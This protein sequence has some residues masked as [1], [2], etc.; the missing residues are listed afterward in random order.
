MGQH[1]AA[2]HVRVAIERAEAAF[3]RAAVAAGAVVVRADEARALNPHA[4]RA[5]V[6]FPQGGW[7]TLCDEDA[8]ASDAALGALAADVARVLDADVVALRVADDGRASILHLGP[9]GAELAAV[10]LPADLADL[11]L[12]RLR[13][14]SLAPLAVDAAAAGH[15]TG[16][17]PAP[18]AS[19]AAAVDEIARRLGIARA[20]GVSRDLAAAP[21][22]GGRAL[23]LRGPEAQQRRPAAGGRAL[24]R[25]TLALPPGMVPDADLP[26]AP[27]HLQITAEGAPVTGLVVELAGPALELLDVTGLVGWNA[28]APHEGPAPRQLVRPERHAGGALVFRFPDAQVEPPP[29]IAPVAPGPAGVRAVHAHYDA[30]A[31][32]T[33][34]AALRARPRRAGEG[35]LAVR[36]RGAGAEVA[37]ASAK[38]HVQAPVGPS[39]RG[40]SA[41]MA[42]PMFG[43]VRAS[44]QK[45]YEG[46]THLVGWIGLDA[47]FEDRRDRVLAIADAVLDATGAPSLGVS[48]ASAGARRALERRWARGDTLRGPAW[49]EL[50]ALLADEAVVQFDAAPGGASVILVHQPNGNPRI[51][52][53]AR[54]ALQTSAQPVPLE[55]AWVLPAPAGADRAALAG[56]ARG[57]VEQAAADRACVGA[58]AAVSGMPFDLLAGTPYEL[59]AGTAVARGSKAWM[60]AHARTPAFAVLVPA[61]AGPVEAPPGS[62]VHVAQAA[63]GWLVTMAAADP[64]A[65]GG[66]E[67]AAVERAVAPCVGT[68]P[69]AL[70]HMEAL[71][72]RA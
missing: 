39:P 6:V 30:R 26:E 48:T 54:D 40:L 22:P 52:R 56:R 2:V 67:R 7:S 50:V 58:F 63:A 17:I 47:R 65:G 68:G 62:G 5:V 20:A 4:L 35:A 9:G 3:E 21:P 16:G 19:S 46:R 27:P 34:E 38:V 29:P 69:E 49:A 1:I 59:L 10:H 61:G 11:D 14:P 24:L 25:A 72:R 66:A 32:A 13:L 15:L 55:V 70:A 42:S 12:A 23:L 57:L 33:F 44:W 18:R 31:R 43:G 53:R 37:E 64:F 36:V 45:A 51:E 8:E 71:A 41:A 28:R 60:A